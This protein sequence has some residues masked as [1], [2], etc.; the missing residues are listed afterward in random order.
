MTEVVPTALPR[1]HALDS[2]V[3][4]GLGRAAS[5]YSSLILALT[6]TLDLT[7]DLDFQSQKQKFKLNGQSVQKIE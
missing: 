5:Q 3:A 1:P 4:A 6:L 2:T 7:Y